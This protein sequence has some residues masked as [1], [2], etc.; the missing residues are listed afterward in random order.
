MRAPPFPRN[1]RLLLAIRLAR[2]LGQGVTVASF[3]LYLQALGYRGPAIGVI[4]TAGLMF[5]ALLTLIIGPLSDRRGRRNLLIG[6][7]AAAAL[8][9]AAAMLSHNEA[10]LIVATTIAGFGRGANGAAG[11]FAPVEQAWL[12][13]E[14]EGA[15]RRRALALNAALGFFGMALGAALVSLPAIAGHGF[16]DIEN[17]RLLFAVPLLG[18]LFGIALLGFA[19]EAV[20]QPVAMPG[21]ENR[22]T[23][24]RVT[25][26]ENRQLRRLATANA[27]NGLGIGIVGPLMAYWFASRFGQSPAMIGPALAAAFLAG[28]FSSLLGGK[29]SERL[30]AVRSVLWMRSAGIL[31]LVAVP[32]APGFG[33]AVFLYALRGAC[34]RGTAGPRQSVAADL[35]RPERRG[36][37]ASVQTLSLQIPRAAGPILGGWLIHA[38]QF[39]APFLIAAA[40]QTLY[41]VLYRYYFGTLN[42][43]SE[44]SQAPSTLDVTPMG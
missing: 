40:L 11:P 2:S 27:I 1:V 44:V 38:G 15:A 12:A 26:E 17:Y 42:R 37:G 32:F 18:S 5:G 13:R 14:L 23:V 3:T 33:A 36:L 20:V 21:A 25:R 22:H 31:L 34:N 35:T 28:A 30:G 29:L 9:A 39:T 10:I 4:L 8:A 16:T 7:E 41:L 24:M 43:A 19:R 6:Y